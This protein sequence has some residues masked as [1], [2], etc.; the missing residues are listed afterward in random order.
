MRVTQDDDLA[1]QNE[2][3]VG[4]IECVPIGKKRLAESHTSE[5][6]AKGETIVGASFHDRAIE[7]FYFPVMVVVSTLYQAD[8]LLGEDFFR[9]CNYITLSSDRKIVLQNPCRWAGGGS[10][11]N[12]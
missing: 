6:F 9:A 5:G 8:L 10:G 2:K 11:P 1:N 12:I 3:S 7:T 4:R